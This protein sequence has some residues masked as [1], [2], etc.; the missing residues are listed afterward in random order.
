MFLAGESVENIAAIAY[1]FLS[2]RFGA[3][4]VRK[5]LSTWVELKHRTKNANTEENKELLARCILEGITD[6]MK[7]RKQ[8]VK[9]TT[10]EMTNE[11]L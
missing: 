6:S 4:R 10:K 11:Q 3:K 1:P 9:P 8:P 5:D 2:S 7:I